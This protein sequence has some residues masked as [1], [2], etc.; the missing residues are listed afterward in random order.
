MCSLTGAALTVVVGVIAIWDQI[1]NLQLNFGCAPAFGSYETAPA[2]A[3]RPTSDAEYEYSEYTYS[4][5][6][7]MPPAAR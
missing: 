6:S 4:P 7:D 2:A 5:P 1:L 3:P